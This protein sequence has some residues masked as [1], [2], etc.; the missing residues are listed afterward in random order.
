MRFCQEEDDGPWPGDE[1][2]VN[3]DKRLEHPAC[4]RVLDRWPLLIGKRYAT[5]FE[6]LAD[7]I[8][9]GGLHQP[10][11]RHHHQQGHDPLGFFEI[12]QRGQKARIFKEPKAAFGVLLTFIAREHCLRW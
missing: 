3:P 5:A 8:F 9:Q 7:A 12:E 11:H 4:G 2:Q 10:T 6:G 1:S